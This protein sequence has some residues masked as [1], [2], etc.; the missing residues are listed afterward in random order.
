M[1]RV[2]LGE[3]GSRGSCGEVS[4]DSRTENKTWAGF[5]AVYVGTGI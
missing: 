4:G 2:G 3:P 5:W 1:L